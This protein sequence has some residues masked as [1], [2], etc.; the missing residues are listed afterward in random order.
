AGTGGSVLT[1][2]ANPGLNAGAGAGCTGAS[3]GRESAVA[4]SALPRLS[5]RQWAL[6]VKDLL[7]LDTVPAVT[8]F[9]NDPPSATG[10][11]NEGGKLDVG[12]G[13]QSDYQS[14]AEALAAQVASDAAKLAK[15]VPAGLATGADA[16]AKGFVEGFGQRAFRRPLTAAESD[17]FVALFKQGP[18][19]LPGR[20]ALSAGAELTIQAMLQSPQFLYRDEGGR[21]ADASG[22]QTLNDYQIAT[23]LSYMLWDSMPDATLFAAAKAGQ[24][25][26]ATKLENEARRLL[27]DRRA[28][29]KL[30]EFHRQLL[31]LPRYD[32]LQPMGLP[33]GIGAALRQETERFVHDAV[34]EHDGGLKTLLTANYSFVNAAVASVYGL[35][36]SF[37]NGFVRAD[38]PATQRAGLLTQPGFLISRAGDT[39]P[40][41]R[42]VFINQKLLC[43]DLPPPPVFTPPKLVGETRR[44]RINSITGLGTCGESCHAR[45][46]NPAG[47]PLEF[48]DNAGRYRAQ[49]N[50]RPVDGSASYPFSDGD[51]SYNGPVEWSR[52]LVQSQQTHECYVRHWLEFG[53]GR[54]RAAGDAPLIQ[55]VGDASRTRELSAKALLIELVKSPS[56]VSRRAEVQ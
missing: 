28:A 10:F 27:Q 49:D 36:G 3:C 7:M 16:Q 34:V 52:A 13:L 38:L 42:G 1:G 51:A 54:G 40:I 15:I 46:I 23:R 50:G 12:Q 29:D 39:A 2:K 44:E 6:T 32:T 33:V 55:R 8:T 56:F 14:S 35:Q 47:F 48:F 31:E 22:V 30:D 20:E 17:R 19:L 43:A 9:T 11:D 4:S 41:L 45:L 24:L 53:F 18:Q 37:G 5:H 26:D 25:Q 21:P